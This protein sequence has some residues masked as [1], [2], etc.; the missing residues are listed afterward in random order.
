MTATHRPTDAAP[1]ASGQELTAL[2]HARGQRATPQRL[3]ILRE[4]RRR[5]RHTTADDL[6]RSITAEL[7]GTSVPTLYATLDLL[8]ELG[9]ARRVDAGGGPA[10]Y[11]PRVEPH[12]HMVCKQCGQ[13]ED[14]DH[15][16]DAEPLLRAASRRGFAGRSVEVV[17]SGLCS[18]CAAP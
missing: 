17:V 18:R 5:G 10:L 6:R 16:V 9:L 1:E 15:A 2:L 7:P 11:D 14:L 12:P 4:L 8:A 13:I 3:V